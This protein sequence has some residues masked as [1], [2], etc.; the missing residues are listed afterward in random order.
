MKRRI[1]N[2]IVD[3]LVELVAEVEAAGNL[4]VRFAAVQEEKQL[5]KNLMKINWF[6]NQSNPVYDSCFG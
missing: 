5:Y 2:N 3:V 1:L 4:N 6:L